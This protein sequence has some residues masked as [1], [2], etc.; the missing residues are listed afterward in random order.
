MKRLL[1]WA[2]TFLLTFPTILPAQDTKIYPSRTSLPFLNVATYIQFPGGARLTDGAA[3]LTLAGGQLV[4]PS[5]TAALPSVAVGE[6]STG[7]LLVGSGELGISILGTTRININDTLL[8]FSASQF[9]LGTD[10]WLIRESADV[11]QS[12]ID[13]A[14]PIA[15]TFKGPD[16]SGVDKTAGN[17][18]LAPGRPTGTGDPGTIC[19][20]VA[21]A[22]AASGSS[23]QAL[24]NRVCINEY[25]SAYTA[26]TLG[27]LGTP[28]NG[29]VTYCSDCAIANPCTGSS[30][31]A[32]AKRLNSVWVCN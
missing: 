8:A 5:G 18:T 9:R 26:R 14:V 15:Q 32:M 29:T 25:G 2:L 3:T 20:S 4:V 1:V 6:A 17:M 10:T 30:T 28:A 19:F 11:W 27:T 31:G 22:A 16:G 21:S 13:A 12:G 24:V 23:Q 7:L